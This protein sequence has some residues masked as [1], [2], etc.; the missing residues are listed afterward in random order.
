MYISG[1]FSWNL[2]W[3][4]SL[5]RGTKG[6]RGF[7]Y[8]ILL[9]E[10]LTNRNAGKLG[11]LFKDRC[12]LINT[13]QYLNITACVRY[14]INSVEWQSVVLRFSASFFSAKARLTQWIYLFRILQLIYSLRVVFLNYLGLNIFFWRAPTKVVWNLNSWTVCITT[15]FTSDFSSTGILSLG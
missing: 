11:Q 5:Y 14:P 3:K 10:T 8:I 13:V 15:Y 6:C 7:L 1:R 4:S 2:A 9:Y 12:L